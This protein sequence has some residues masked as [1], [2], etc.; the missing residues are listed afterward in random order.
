MTCQM[1][2]YK[3]YETPVFAGTFRVLSG[4]AAIIIGLAIAVL[5]DFKGHGLGWL[6]IFA[7]P[8]VFFKDKDN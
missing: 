3:S 2:G 7:A 8:F 5:T 4:L 6:L 1:E